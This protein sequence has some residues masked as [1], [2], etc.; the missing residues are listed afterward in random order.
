MGGI[1]IR[2]STLE[3]HPMQDRPRHD[4]RAQCAITDAPSKVRS[5]VYPPTMNNVID[6][7]IDG[8]LSRWCHTGGRIVC[9]W[10]AYA[11]SSHINVRFL[12]IHAISPEQGDDTSLF[13]LLK[14]ARDFIFFAFILSCSLKQFA[15]FYRA[16]LL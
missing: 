5:N 7:T 6:S 9:C 12:L 10:P 15:S 3:V 8:T 16:Q 4:L 11:N 14:S 2:V 1:R 13:S